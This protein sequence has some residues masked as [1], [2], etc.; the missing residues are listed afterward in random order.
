MI[1]R[2]PLFLLVLYMGFVLF[3]N[4][5]NSFCWHAPEFASIPFLGLRFRAWIALIPAPLLMVT[6]VTLK[7]LESSTSAA[8]PSVAANCLCVA[9]CPAWWYSRWQE[10]LVC[11][12]QKQADWGPSGTRPIQAC[13]CWSCLKAISFLWKNWR[14]RRCWINSQAKSWEADPDQRRGVM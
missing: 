9:Q 13:S 11:R 7:L 1:H 4:V 12:G 10:S 8:M 6:K 3:E 2:F 5:F 14:E